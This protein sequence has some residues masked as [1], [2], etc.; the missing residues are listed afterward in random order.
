MVKK[1]N[2]LQKGTR[3]YVVTNDFLYFFVPKR[4]GYVCDPFD[5]SHMESQASFIALMLHCPYFFPVKNLVHASWDTR[6]T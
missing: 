5:L 2:A 3:F 4:V 1:R 6:G